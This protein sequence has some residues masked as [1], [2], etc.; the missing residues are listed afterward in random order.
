MNNYY[1]LV[2]AGGSGTRFWPLSRKRLPKQFLSIDGRSES[3]IKMTHNRLKKTFD[4]KNIF[5]VA[6]PE[7]SSL[8]SREI[9]DI[10]AANIILEPVP[11]NTAP[12]IGLSAAIISGKDEEAVI[13]VLPSDHYIKDEALFSNV[14]KAAYQ[15]AREGDIITIGITPDRPETGF[16]YIRKGA[17][18]SNIDGID[19]HG[20]EAFIEKPNRQ[21]AIEYLSTGRYL[22]NAGIFVFTAKKILEEMGRLMPQTLD[23]ILR[24][25]DIIG[26]EPGKAKEI[27]S[28]IESISIDYG[29]MEKVS[30]IRVIPADLKWSDVGSWGAVRDILQKDNYGNVNIGGNIL[31]DCQDCVVRS[32]NR[33]V[34]VIGMNSVAVIATDDAILVTPLEKCQDVKKVVDELDRTGKKGLV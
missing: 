3:L 7:Y 30:G 2:M 20:V 13:A 14:L 18:I 33:T 15:A 10:P 27:F 8:I 17:L 5:F 19:I 24:V 1:A 26:K 31:I 6:N 9:T 12:A 11:K 29:I 28:S 23:A 32:E 16:G 4:T 25:R 21:K 34:A 22:W